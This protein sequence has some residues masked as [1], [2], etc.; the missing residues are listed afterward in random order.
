MISGNEN[1]L[2]KIINYLKRITNI[3]YSKILLFKTFNELNKEEIYTYG[4]CRKC[5]GI[6]TR[7]FKIDNEVFNYSSAKFLKFMLENHFSRNQIRDFNYNISD[8]I[9]N[10]K[11]NHYINKDISRIFVTRYGS[12]IFEYDDIIKHYI[13]PMNLNID[14][15]FNKN[16]LFKIYENLGYY[17]CTNTLKIIQT[18]LSNQ[19][20]DFKE[21]FEDKKLFIFK[22]LINSI[23]NDI[24]GMEYINKN[25]MTDIINKYLKDNNDKYN[26]CYIKLIVYVKKIYLKLVKIKLILNN[27]E[28]LKI[29]IKVISDILNNKI[30]ITLEEYKKNLSKDN[31]LE[32]LPSELD[33]EKNHIYYKN[34]LNFLEYSDNDHDYYSCELSQDDL[35]SLIANILSSN[36]YLKSMELE[37]GLNLALIKYKRNLNEIISDKITNN[38]LRKRKASSSKHIPDRNKDFIE[39]NK[40]KLSDK[41][42]NLKKDTKDLYDTMLTFDLSKQYFYIEGEK[43]AKYSNNFIKKI[44]E[45]EIISNEKEHKIFYLN[46]DL[47]S[48]LTNKK[49]KK[50]MQK[51]E[52]I[53]D[54]NMINISSSNS[55]DNENSNESIENSNMNDN[56]II[57]VSFEYDFSKMFKKDFQKIDL[58][59]ND[60]EIQLNQLNIEFKELRDKLLNIIKN[61]LDK[62]KEKRKGSKEIKEEIKETNE[63]IKENFDNTNK[64]PINNKYNEIKNDN[65]NDNNNNDKNNIWKIFSTNN[66]NDKIEKDNKN[67]EILNEEEI[68]PLFQ[69]IPEF[70]KIAKT[71]LHIYLEEE[72]I[73][74]ELNNIEIIVYYPKQFEALRIVYCANIEDFIISLSKSSAWGENTGGKSKSSFYKTLDEKYILKNVNENEFNMFLDN[75]I[76]YFNYISQFLFNKMPSLLAK[77]LGA[78]KITIKQNN[79]EMKYYLILM[80]N[81]FYGIMSKNNNNFNS[82]ESYLKVYDLKG[83]NINRY[84]NKNMRNPGQVLLD[85]NFLVDFNKEPVNIDANIYDKLKIALHNDTLYLKKLE[86]VDYSLLIIF[87]NKGNENKNEEISDNTYNKNN[88]E[89]KNILSENENNNNQRM[90]KLGI[91]DYIRKYTWDKKMEF[92]GKS[93]IYGENPTIVDPNIYSERFY[94]KIISY[95]VGI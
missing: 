26:N 67:D 65:N 94:K 10:K 46:N 58:Y 56:I 69:N 30:P 85:T 72:I 53:L 91:I 31:E 75:G 15:S 27:L 78:F 63:N 42:L 45:E 90:I 11:C 95:F 55:L 93:I 59:F 60:I 38:I 32:N 33:F 88:H 13:S 51:P 87:D 22:E 49:R 16:N 20:N 28:R 12:W 76:E 5:K 25:F 48:I 19:E 2:D 41:T 35:T 50:K 54:L 68:I 4:Y 24:K 43:G 39:T 44:L 21:L 40:N 6:V 17:N 3:D 61:K 70:E 1:D 74:E 62:L 23:L 37:N 82:P 52:D 80:E 9:V 29:N 77:I 36:E 81:I 84:I 7:L 34:I 47:F 83:S 71:Q 14:Y 73:F 57:N 66:N 79:K 86:I 8:I 89:A 92:Y 18:V 64:E